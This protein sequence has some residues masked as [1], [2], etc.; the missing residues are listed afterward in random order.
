MKMAVSRVMYVREQVK[1][2]EDEGGMVRRLR[3]LCH[4]PTPPGVEEE[5][6]ELCTAGKNPSPASMFLPRAGLQFHSLP[7]NKWNSER[8]SF[9]GN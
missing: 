8:G 1:R 2:R 9:Q 4:M 6:E 3:C 7:R 5:Q